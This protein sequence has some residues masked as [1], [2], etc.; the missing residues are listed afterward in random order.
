[1]SFAAPTLDEGAAHGDV[2]R[3]HGDLHLANIVL[4]QG[5]PVAYDAIAFD[6]AVATIDTLHDRRV[7][8]MLR[9][10]A[11]LVLAAGHS[12]IH[13]CRVCRARRTPSY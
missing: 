3:C 1:V 9:D 13:R 11:R 10:K 2:R 8:A 12:L 7:Y 6:D 5:R 4:W